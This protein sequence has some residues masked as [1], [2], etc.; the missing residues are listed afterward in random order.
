MKYTPFDK[1]A[2]TPR[3]MKVKV[4]LKVIGKMTL[5]GTPHKGYLD[6]GTELKCQEFHHRPLCN[7]TFH[8]NSLIM[9]KEYIN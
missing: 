5:S 7:M 3:W 2:P 8:I 1:K 6:Q 4:L 9:A